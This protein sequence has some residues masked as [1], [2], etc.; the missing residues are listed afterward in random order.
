[1]EKIRLN[2]KEGQDIIKQ[3]PV[4]T[5]IVIRGEL[6]FAKHMT[7]ALEG[8]DLEKEVQRQMKNGLRQPNRTPRYQFSLV[9]VT[10]VTNGRT[11]LNTAEQWLWQKTYQDKDGRACLT[12]EMGNKDYIDKGMVYGNPIFG[13][14]D[15]AGIIPMNIMGQSIAAGQ[16]VTVTFSTYLQRN[17]DESVGFRNVV[18][19][20]YPQLFVPQARITPAGWVMDGGIQQ[21]GTP[22][23]P[24]VA[25]AQAPTQAASVQQAVAPVNPAPGFT[26]APAPAVAAPVNPVPQMAP[27]QATAPAPGFIPAPQVSVSSAWD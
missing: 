19:D 5:D 20:S 6:S 9:D 15:T 10:L 24:E 13:Y 8:E 25:P 23:T 14:R 1:M 2:T 12:V 3:T 26:P 18:F 4:N 11:E 27:T 21:V 22:V 16:M 17:G 7:K